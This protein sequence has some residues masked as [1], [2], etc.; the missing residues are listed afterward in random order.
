MLLSGTCQRMT[1][2]G[3]RT[4]PLRDQTGWATRCAAVLI[5]DMDIVWTRDCSP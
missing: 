5:Q 2:G 3:M 4:T 1:G